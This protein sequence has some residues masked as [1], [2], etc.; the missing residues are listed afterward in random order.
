METYGVSF[1][2]FEPSCGWAMY[3][4]TEDE[5]LPQLRAEV[6]RWRKRRDEMS[7]ERAALK[8]LKADLEGLAK[9]REGL[10]SKL[11]ANW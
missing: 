10:A 11:Q 2:G 9:S 3:K 1:E 5:F 8:G 7:N 6:E 4:H